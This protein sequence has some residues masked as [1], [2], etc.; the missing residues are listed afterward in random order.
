[1]DSA[2]VATETKERTEAGL[3]TLDTP[4]RVLVAVGEGPLRRAL[5][6]P[7]EAAGFEVRSLPDAAGLVAEAERLGPQLVLLSDDPGATTGWQAVVSLRAREA[8]FAL[9]IAAV[10]AAPEVPVVV[11]WLAFGAVDV[12]P[13][14]PG[15]DVAARAR[16]LIDECA[17]TQVQSARVTERL[18]AF[19]RRAALTGTLKVY[20]GTP[21]EGA[22]SF[23]D[24]RL[25]EASLGP[26]RDSTALEQLVEHDAP[27]AWVGAQPLPATQP[28]P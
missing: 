6:D 23:L 28:T 8:T 13:E 7:L 4:R 25:L 5:V 16:A 26:L 22:A 12:W 27:V 21:F 2:A 19:A 18:L 11:R 3:S 17:L 20:A 24:G 9:P 10:L 15:P 1:V 14:E